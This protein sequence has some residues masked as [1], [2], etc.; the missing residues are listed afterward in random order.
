MKLNFESGGCDS[1]F[2]NL[3]FCFSRRLRIVNQ[4]QYS[5]LDRDL[6]KVWG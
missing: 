4:T 5:A 2:V 6:Y 3:Q 1:K